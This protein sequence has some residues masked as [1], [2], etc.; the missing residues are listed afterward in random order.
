MGME[1]CT[2]LGPVS[3]LVASLIADPGVVNPNPA[4]Y[5]CGDH[6]T[7]SM[8]T[9]LRLSQELLLSVAS[10]SICSEY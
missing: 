7:F 1:T 4:S 9:L 10:K 2:L 5:F 6:E 8:V 3:Y